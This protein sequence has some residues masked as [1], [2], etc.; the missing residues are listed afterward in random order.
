ML[1]PAPQPIEFSLSELVL[2]LHVLL[3]V[4]VSLHILMTHED[5]RSAVAWT[6]L[7]WLSPFLGSAL[8]WLFGIN[9]IRRR[10]LRLRLPYFEARRGRALLSPA[11]DFL[12]ALPQNMRSL[13]Q[14]GREITRNPLVGGN[15]VVAYAQPAEAYREME[16]AIDNASES[17]SLSSYIFSYDEAGRP[18]VEA[19]GR[20]VKRGVEVRVLIDDV[21]LKYSYPTVLRPLRRLGVEVAR[22]LPTLLPWEF[23]YMNLRNHRKLLLV[24]G[25]KAFVGGLNIRKGY[26]PLGTRSATIQD[27]H[28]AIQGPVVRQLQAVFAEDWGF[29]TGEK[30]ESE[31][32]FPSEIPSTGSTFCR[33]VADGPD[34]SRNLLDHILFASITKAHLQ[35]DIVT[36]YFLPSEELMVALASAAMSGLR[37]RI[38]LPRVNNLRF[39]RWASL[40]LLPRLIQAG[41]EIYESE[42]P[43]D[44]SKLMIVDRSWSFCGSANWDPRSLRL[45]FELNV[46]I[47]DPAFA[48]QM[49]KQ[50]EEKIQRARRLD[51]KSLRATSF[52][53][54]LRNKTAFLFH[55]YL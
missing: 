49:E 14:L 17:L 41:C 10:A 18:L 42:P 50:V 47:F 26:L 22:F 25:R 52:A 48:R 36:P 31:K 5:S 39:V 55:P 7:V 13:A 29:T 40:A 54:H 45:N 51:L 4:G 30:L 12:A 28:F 38:V 34:D 37:V 32:W 3:S 53:A 21:G 33:A 9:R 44:H 1:S 11:S 6:G 2:A 16:R 27:L 24:D 35:V 15:S 43:F 46:E 20:A 23:S 8:Y 19:L